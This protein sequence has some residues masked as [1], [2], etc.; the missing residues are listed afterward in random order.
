MRSGWLSLFP[1]VESGS[2]SS[3]PGK[4]EEREVGVWRHLGRSKSVGGP[5]REQAFRAPARGGAPG[6]AQ[7][8]DVSDEGLWQTRWAPGW[9][10]ENTAR[11]VGPC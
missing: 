3:G 10:S 1:F 8:P 9:V 6:F 4:G 2:P 11:P 7:E 5:R